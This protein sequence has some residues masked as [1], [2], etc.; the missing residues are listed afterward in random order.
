MID[1]LA[2]HGI[3]ASD[4][5]RSL[6]TTHT[7]PN[8]GY[9]PGSE[10]ETSGAPEPESAPAKDVADTPSETKPSK[11]PAVPE[12]PADAKEPAQAASE[13]SLIHI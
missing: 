12:Q 7:I 6:I 4:L 5:A 10:E 3:L 8:P 1:S 9:V 11:E 2:H 13:L